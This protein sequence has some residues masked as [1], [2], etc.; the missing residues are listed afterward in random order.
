[1]AQWG[2]TSESGILRKNKPKENHDDLLVFG[3]ACKLFRDDEKASY[4]DKGKHLIP[5]MG[6][7]KLKID[8]YDCRG[9]LSDIAPYEASREG[10][11]AMRWLGLSDSERKLEQLCDKERYYSLHINEEEEQM[12]KEEEQKRQKANEFQ[13]SYD[14]PTD[15]AQVMA[16][17]VPE[18]EEED[19]EYVPSPHLDV[20]I[21]ISIPK[22]V[23]ENT[24]IEKTALFICK[25]G[26]QMEILIKAKQADN[27]Q[28]GFLNQG[29]ELYKYYRHVLAAITSGRYQVTSIS[30]KEE[31]REE[32][33]ENNSSEDHYLHPSLLSTS[34]QPDVQTSSIP[35][36]PYKPSAN[37]SYSQLVNRIQGNSQSDTSQ[38]E[39]SK[40]PEALAQMTYE[41]QQYYQYYYTAQYYEYY[42]Q[43]AQYQQ[44]QGQ[45]VQPPDTQLDP[46]VQSYI[47]QMAYAQYIQH[48]S[49]NTNPY[50]QIV[51]NVSSK[52]VSNPYSG[53]L[54]SLPE[55]NHIATTKETHVEETK[56]PAP[57]GEPDIGESETAKKT[58]LCLAQYGSDSDSEADG[59]GE[60]K[61]EYKIPTGE[62]QIVIDKMAT[63]VAKNGV[64][65]EEI[66]KAKGDPRFEFLN[67][68]HEFY[69]YY[70]S[71]I[72]NATETD[73]KETKAV[74]VPPPKPK[75]KKVIA[76]V[77]FSIKKPK[78]DGPKE[79]RSALP[80]EESD[81]EDTN[82]SETTPAA[83][84][85]NSAK[86]VESSNDASN[87]SSH[88]NG[89]IFDGDD[90]IL[91]MIDLTDDIEERK[92]AKRAEDKIK[93][94]LAA[95]A[96][97]K[98][99][100]VARDRALQL[101]RKKKAAAF[102]K[103]KSAENPV[104]EE[105]KS[106]TPPAEEGKDASRKKSRSRERKKEVVQIDDSADEEDK[107]KK[108]SKK[109]KSHKRYPSP[110]I[111]K[112]L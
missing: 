47:Q 70:K 6:D 2:T 75:E 109:K 44:G 87:E 81:D 8:R 25:Q 103:L 91:E 94:K 63:Y 72:K 61:E 71:K 101:E 58:L 52:E 40:P 15:P 64:Q 45:S 5:W 17:T 82:M 26:P 34:T 95:A 49:T 27:P 88:K 21:D 3:Y 73:K 98:M 43:L 86:E 96:R 77:S 56:A 30:K 102:L 29:H 9:A 55:Q 104:V 60:D 57:K 90:P 13:Y 23:K 18:A 14:V 20:P 16:P 66:V 11:D 112:I 35:S 41:Q 79:I 78:D 85:D 53:M 48:Q 1:M 69:K 33:T 54:A 36:I 4:I 107:K 12:Y 37:C 89:A 7:E 108:S 32:S 68:N 42:K 28:F 59:E 74:A 24:R 99:V 19:E 105:G 92:D 83:T 62:V 67:E 93:D 46:G 39:A 38:V 111:F 84:T 10:F 76:P 97:E 110:K 106:E 65:F 100:S 80:V 51:S 22:T 50:A 31:K